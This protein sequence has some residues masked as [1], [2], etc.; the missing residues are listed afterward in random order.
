MSQPRAGLGEPGLRD[1][2]TTYI[3]AIVATTLFEDSSLN[4]NF[5]GTSDATVAVVAYDDGGGQLSLAAAH[6]ASGYRPGSPHPEASSLSCRGYK[7][8]RLTYSAWRL[9]Y[10]FSD[11]IEAFDNPL[12]EDDLI[13]WGGSEHQETYFEDRSPEPIKLLNSAG[14]PFES[15]PQRDAAGM[16]ATISRN[17]DEVPVLLMRRYMHAV[18]ASAFRL[19]GVTIPPRVAKIG[20]ISASGKQARNGVDYR[21]LTIPISFSDDGETWRQRYEDR[22]YN[23]L[24]SGDFR[25]IIAGTPPSKPPAPWP[26][27]GAGRKRDNADDNPAILEVLP[28]RELSFA[29]WRFR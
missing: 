10:E 18:N 12:N 1:R 4:L 2:S 9:D 26:L 27:D 8:K 15:L 25:E 11:E 14:E 6:N 20:V 19:D 13:E 17:V 3:V 16:M 5:A 28:Y 22:G 24:V 29:P 21:T 7:P 23:E